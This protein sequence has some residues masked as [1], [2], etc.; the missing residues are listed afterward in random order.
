MEK[1]ILRSDPARSDGVLRVFRAKKRGTGKRE[2]KANQTGKGRGVD[3]SEEP[4]G[5]TGGNG[6]EIAKNNLWKT[7]EEKSAPR[8][9]RAGTPC[10]GN[11]R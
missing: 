10:D 6:K 9:K 4:K 7:S 3:L 8:R 5:E 1:R 11:Q 2:A